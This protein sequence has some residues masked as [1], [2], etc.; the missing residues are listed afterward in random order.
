MNPNLKVCEKVY[1]FFCK[2]CDY[3]CIKQQHYDK[4]VLIIE[5]LQNIPQSYPQKSEQ[6]LIKKCMIIIV[7]NVIIH[8]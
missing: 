7:K 8:V 1:N 6:I 2:K 4:N 5:I 3:K